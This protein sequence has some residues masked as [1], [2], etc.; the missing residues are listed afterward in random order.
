MSTC[1][2]EPTPIG[3][4]WHGQGML[5]GAEETLQA[6]SVSVLLFHEAMSKL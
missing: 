2:H 6:G 4:V 1:G 3:S 5:H